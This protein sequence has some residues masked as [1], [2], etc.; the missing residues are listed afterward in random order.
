MK[1]LLFSHSFTRISVNT[2]LANA[3]QVNNSSY[4]SSEDEQQKYQRLDSTASYTSEDEP[5]SQ[6]NRSFVSQ[7]SENESI[8][9]YN[10]ESFDDDQ[11]QQQS[12]YAPEAVKRSFSQT[13]DEESVT[14]KRQKLRQ[15]HL[16]SLSYLSHSHI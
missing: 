5:N 6:Q 9:Y 2:G 13:S 1:N 15:V 14:C 8:S 10:P 11:Q 7:Q 16:F 12:Y 3:S 4:A